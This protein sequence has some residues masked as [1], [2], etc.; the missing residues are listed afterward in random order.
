MV[1]NA[2]E[3]QA[4]KDEWARRENLTLKQKY[5]ILDAM[6]EEAI[7]LGVLPGR[8]PLEGVEYVMRLAKDINGVPKAA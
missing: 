4:L 3:L 1:E 8:D 7:L 5:A 6:Y 2:H